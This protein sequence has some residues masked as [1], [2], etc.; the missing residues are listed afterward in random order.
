[1]KRMGK[2]YVICLDSVTL[3]DWESKVFPFWSTQLSKSSKE[4]PSCFAHS[5]ALLGTWRYVSP[6]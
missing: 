5:G 1:M 6:F 3:I 2:V 4:S